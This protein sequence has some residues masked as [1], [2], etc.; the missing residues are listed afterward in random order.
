MTVSKPRAAII[1][2]LIGFLLGLSVFAASRLLALSMLADDAILAAEEVA[3]RLSAGEQVEATGALSAVLGYTRFDSNGTVV[4]TRQFA[5]PARPR[6]DADRQPA[7]AGAAEGG[8][9]ILD[10]TPLIPTLLGLSGEAIATVAA[11]VSAGGQ[12]L[13]SVHVEVDQTSALESFT[14]RISTIAIV[15]L[16]LGVLAVAAVSFAVSRGRSLARSGRRFDPAMLARDGLTGLPSRESFPAAL[17][18]AIERAIEADRQ[19]G[20]LLIDLKGIRQVN[21]A[22]GHSVGDRIL[23]DAAK[24]LTPYAARPELLARLDG[25]HF[26]LIL[27]GEATSHA[28]R[29]AAEDIRRKTEAPHPLEGATVK[30]GVSIGAAVYPVNADNAERLFQ[31]AE[32]ALSKAK[33]TRWEALAFFDTELA[34]RMQ[35]RTALERDLRLAL[36]RNEF[37][38]FYQPQLEL[39]SGRR[40]GYEAL[41]RWERPGSGILP[42]SEFLPVAEENGLIHP[43]GEWVLRKACTDAKAWPEHAVVAVNFCAAQLRAGDLDALIERV[44]AETGLPPGRLE[45]EIPESLFLEGTPDLLSLLA[46]VK[47]LGVRVAMDNFGS[48]YSGLASLAQFPFDKVKIDRAFVSQLAEDPDVAAIVAAIVGLGRSLSLDIS[49]EGV[50]TDEQVTM[51]R[52]AGCSIVQGFLFGVPQRDSDGAAAEPAPSRADGS[53]SAA[54]G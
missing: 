20:L 18:N 52:A 48:G 50:E 14:R 13:G 22:W 15:S 16:C 27:E 25:D 7:G 41:V 38:L 39:A 40:R 19:V 30:L 35:R 33:A 28:L 31:A 5:S 4:D 26:A 34:K 12:P 32:A 21:Q 17:A 51:L 3:A 44:L 9:V 6:P 1:V 46:R 47:G 29:Q 49:A 10:N 8:S 11:A 54:A 45:I 36:E 43:I 37:V 42:P 53:S 23:R 2:F 24:R